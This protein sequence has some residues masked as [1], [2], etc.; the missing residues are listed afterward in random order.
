[1]SKLTQELR[2]FGDF[3]KSETQVA[4]E[5]LKQAGLSEDQAQAEVAQMQFEKEAVE[6]LAM[7]GIDVES[8]VSLVKAANINVRELTG[9]VDKQEAPES[10]LFVKVAEYVEH[11]EA[12]V[13]DLQDQVGELEKSASLV[14]QDPSW[15]EPEIE[16]PEQF[17]KAASMGVLT[18][19]D[20]EALSKVDQNVLNKIASSMD[21]PWE[22][23][24]P[25]G[26]VR[27]KSDPILDFI[28]GDQ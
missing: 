13:K 28:Y 3:K 26:I 9:V 5:L 4:V 18:K 20:L 16:V 8:A 19:S 22:M 11:L 6:H 25:S 23:G 14:I 2:A 10:D 12:Q 15:I 17:T 7:S 21:R 24:A 1:M 27:P